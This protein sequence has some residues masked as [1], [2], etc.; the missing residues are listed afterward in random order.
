MNLSWK[1]F[2]AYLFSKR[3]GAAIKTISRISIFNV[4]VGI[5]SFIIVMS[6]MSGFRDSLTQRFFKIEP[7][8][9]VEGEL[10]E[11]ETLLLKNHPN[12]RQIARYSQSD[13]I[14]RTIDGIFNGAVIKGY[15]Q[16]FLQELFSRML[17]A[18]PN[19]AEKKILMASVQSLK[20]NEIIM[21][22]N[23]AYAL[24]VIEG[25]ELVVIP[26]ETLLLPAGEAPE[27]KKVIIAATFTSDIPDIDARSIFYRFNKGHDEFNENLSNKKGFEFWLHEPY[28]Y[29]NF[30]EVL[31]KLNLKSQSWKERNASL[32][33]AISLEK[34]TM[35]TFLFL[36]GLIT[37]LSIVSVM[38]L[39]L[40]QKQ[41]DIGILLTLGLSRKRTQN[42]FTTMGLYLSYMGLG[43]GIILGL[44][45]C[46]YLMFFPLDILS[47]IYYD[48]T[49]PV[50]IS[51][52][53]VAVV[54]VAAAI[55]SF[56]VSWLP[57]RQL[58]KIS[59]VDCLRK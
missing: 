7:H 14:V 26:P 8:V 16:N 22:S 39:L 9:A 41:S 43:L 56:I 55:I 23:L 50:N 19:N 48:T 20:P 57:T 54:I 52:F 32:F 18:R 4:C 3:S 44:A 38:V 37:C 27:Y 10:G 28:E 29:T 59:P 12:V 33:Y 40:L 25:D 15:E 46:F 45:V 34:Y 1:I 35:G 13:V 17:S 53:F 24:N 31:N 47:K 2:K 51:V 5:M 42:T 30:Q 58:L 6:V 21:G 49:I 36:A 11:K